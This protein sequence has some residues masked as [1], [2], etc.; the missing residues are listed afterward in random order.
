MTAALTINAWVR[1][2][3]SQGGGQAAATGNP[4]LLMRSLAFAIPLIRDWVSSHWL[5]RT[6][7]AHAWG[8][9]SLGPIGDGTASS[10]Y[11]HPSVG[12]REMVLVESS[13]Q[14]PLF[15]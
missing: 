15:D 13:P 2:L 11:G 1:W 14:L 5:F 10:T 9:T 3:G 7:C 12:L 4:H 6:N 8:V